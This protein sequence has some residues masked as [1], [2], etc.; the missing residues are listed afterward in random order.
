MNSN[1]QINNHCGNDSVLGC[2]NCNFF[3]VNLLNQCYRCA[4]KF[5]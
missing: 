5:F 4:K 1:K 3:C 2:L